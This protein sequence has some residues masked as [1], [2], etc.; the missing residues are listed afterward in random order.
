MM[1]FA[2]LGVHYLQASSITRTLLL[3]QYDSKPTG[4]GSGSGLGSYSCWSLGS[5]KMKL[6][7]VAG[8]IRE[9]FKAFLVYS[10]PFISVGYVVGVRTKRWKGGLSLV[11]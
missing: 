8:L 7:D 1:E 3:L 10:S 4:L 2:E 6:G 11:V 9:H 5:E